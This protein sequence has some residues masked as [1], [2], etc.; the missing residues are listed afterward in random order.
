MLELTGYNSSVT[1]MALLIV[2]MALQFIIATVAHRK[3]DNMIPGKVDDSLDHHSFV[4][5]SHRAYMNAVEGMSLYFP[6]FVVALL[7]GVS[8]NFVAALTWI[9]LAARIV[10]GVLYYMIATN[11]NPSPR[12]YFWAISFLTTLVL[13]GANVAALF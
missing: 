1:A 11:K 8:A 2:W 13:I 10:H 4:F 9:Y 3:Q 5:R 12:S 6:A 7:L